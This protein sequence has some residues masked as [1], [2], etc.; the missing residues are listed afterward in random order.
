MSCS[1]QSTQNLFLSRRRLMWVPA[2]EIC[3][4][5]FLLTTSPQWGQYRTGAA[6]RLWLRL[7][8]WVGLMR[9]LS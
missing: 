3:G 1:P 6:V 9:A 8:Q 7:G 4:K 2:Q 5:I